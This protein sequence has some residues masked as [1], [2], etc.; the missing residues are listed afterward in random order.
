MTRKLALA[1]AMG[2]TTTLAGSVTP[3]QADGRVSNSKKGSLLIYSKVDLRWNAAGDLMQDTILELTNDLE[4]DV[5]IQMY[6]VNGDEPRDAV[7]A[8]DPPQMIAEGEPGWNWVDLQVLLTANQPVYW[9]ASTGLPL[10]AAPFDI[11]DPSNG[12]GPGRPTADG[13]RMLRGFI[14][15]WAVNAQGAQIRWNHLSGSATIINY[16]AQTAWE[17]NAW[18]FQN[19]SGE[20]GSTVGN[21]GYMALDGISYDQAYDVLLMDFFA[22]GSQALSSDTVT[23]SIDTDLTLHSVSADLRQDT[24]GPITTK[25][26]FDIWNENERRF[27]GTERCITCWDQTLLSNYDAPNH[28]LIQNLQ[29]DKGKARIDGMASSVCNSP[30]CGE[31]ATFDTPTGNGPRVQCSREASLLGVVSKVVAFSGIDSRATRAGRSLVGMGI[32][33]AEI[34]QDIIAPPGELRD[35][36]YDRAGRLTPITGEDTRTFEGSKRLDR[37]SRSR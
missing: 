30:F 9:S 1:L 37:S 15:V 2:I 19:S 21:P 27:S 17:Y 16:G 32:Q 13:G 28:F 25:A 24:R 20:N 33:S 6:F 10:G 35:A 3:V 36:A 12:N 22:S 7:Y 4:Q 11:L 14:Y 18:A 34:M 5:Y 23:A 8:G 26:K 29:T 31:V